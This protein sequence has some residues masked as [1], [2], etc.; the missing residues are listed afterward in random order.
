MRRPTSTTGKIPCLTMSTTTRSPE[1]AQLLGQPL[2]LPLGL[3]EPD[4]GHEF[5]RP[6]TLHTFGDS[7]SRSEQLDT[8]TRSQISVAIAATWAPTSRYADSCGSR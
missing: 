1:P 8:R 2:S 6:T 3:G 7:W 5:R 4:S